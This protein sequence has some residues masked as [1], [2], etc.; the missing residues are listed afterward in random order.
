MKLDKIY[1]NAPVFIQNLACSVFGWGLNR[2]RYGAAYKSLED[3]V[4][5]RLKLSAKD[6]RDLCNQRL[7]TTIRHATQSVPYYQKL[8]ASN[9]IDPNEIRGPAD[10]EQIPLLTRQQIQDRLGDFCSNRNDEYQTSIV[11]T[12]GTTGTGLVFPMTLQAEQEQWAIWWRYRAQF[13]LNRATW[14]AHFYGKSVVPVQ[15]SRPP[16]WRINVP[17]KQILFSGYHMQDNNLPYYIDE[18]N[19][20]KPPWI[21]GYPSLLALLA[22]YMV[23]TGAILD[24]KPMIVTTGAESLLPHQRALIEKAFNTTCR[25]HYGTTEAVVNISECV[26]GRLHVDEDF[27]CVEFLPAGDGVWKIVATG[28]VNPAFVLIRYEVGD[29]V[30][31]PLE[32]VRCGCGHPGRIVEKIDGRIEDYVITTNGV[33]IGRLDHILKDMLNIR[34]AQIIQNEVGKIDFLI[35]KGESYSG[36][37]ESRLITETKKRLGQDMKI[38]V[39]YVQSLERS[40]TGKLRFVVSGLQQGKIRG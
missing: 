4:F 32:P 8:F 1:L 12:S 25:Q 5:D 27:G 2:R 28:Y 7:Q 31:L 21:Q 14:Y 30:V 19:R 11:K 13:K 36:D 3:E 22:G 9:G 34:E 39:K 29:N 24:Y 37:D 33:K 18:L 40:K 10:L 20:R 38:R 35:V 15:Q 17:G 26:N 6:Y 16:F 23:S